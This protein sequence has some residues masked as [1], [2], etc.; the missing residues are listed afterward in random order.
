M[1]VLFVQLEQVSMALAEFEEWLCGVLESAGADGE[2][3]GGYISGTLAAMSGSP[4]E[5]T[6]EAIRD[7][8]SA[9]LV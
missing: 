7:I 1:G 6:E 4:S 9:S 5:E 3:Y 8:L 2:V